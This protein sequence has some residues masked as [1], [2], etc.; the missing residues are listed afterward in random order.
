M[1]PVMQYIVRRIHIARIAEAKPPTF[2]WIEGI[3]FLSGRILSCP[4]ALYQFYL[5]FQCQLSFLIE[6]MSAPFVL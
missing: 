6:R 4:T 1:K 3:K 5:V 2:V